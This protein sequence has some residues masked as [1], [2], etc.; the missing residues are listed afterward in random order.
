MDTWNFSTLMDQFTHFELDNSKFSEARQFGRK[1][2]KFKNLKNLNAPIDF[3][4]IEHQSS[5]VDILYLCKIL[6]R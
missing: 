6:G 1:F 3:G 2:F 4:Q 5:L